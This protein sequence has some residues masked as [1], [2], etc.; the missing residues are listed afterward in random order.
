MIDGSSNGVNRSLPGPMSQSGHSLPFDGWPATSD[1]TS[2]PDLS[3]H[4]VNRRDVPWHKHGD[5]EVEE[6]WPTRPRCAASSGLCDDASRPARAGSMSRAHYESA[7]TRK[8]VRAI[9]DIALSPAS[10]MIFLMVWA[11]P[12]HLAAQPSDA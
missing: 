7:F 11:Q 3:L 9:M 1:F 6:S 4:R 12:P 8:L 10:S 2:T 5:S